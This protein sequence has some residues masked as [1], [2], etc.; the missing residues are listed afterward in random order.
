MEGP[1]VVRGAAGPGVGARN[2]GEAEVVADVVYDIGETASAEVLAHSLAGDWGAEALAKLGAE[3]GV[4]GVGL[5]D[6]VV[7]GA[8]DADAGLGAGAF[9]YVL[10]QE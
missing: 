2:V 7:D 1:D 4:P 6:G 10:G 9:L 8:E 3:A 5:D